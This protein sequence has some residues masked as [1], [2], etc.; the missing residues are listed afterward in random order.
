MSAKT[1]ENIILQT[2]FN[3]AVQ[4]ENKTTEKKKKT[5]PHFNFW[6]QKG[7]KTTFDLKGMRRR[8]VHNKQGMGKKKKGGKKKGRGGSLPEQHSRGRQS[9]VKHLHRFLACGT[10]IVWVSPKPVIRM[11]LPVCLSVCLQPRCS[12]QVGFRHGVGWSIGHGPG[13]WHPPAVPL[14]SLT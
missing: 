7:R 8:S 2:T 13:C 1:Q 3:L 11:H 10:G 6:E 9:K 5:S 4:N 12:S 14:T